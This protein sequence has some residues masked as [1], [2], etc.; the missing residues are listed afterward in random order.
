MQSDHPSLLCMRQHCE[1]SLV[2]SVLALF[3]LGVSLG[4]AGFILSRAF[5][6]QA[7]LGRGAAKALQP[8]EED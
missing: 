3:L 5:R 1:G 4:A 7:A 2:P 8:R 6:R